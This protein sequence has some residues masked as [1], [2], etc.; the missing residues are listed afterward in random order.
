MFMLLA[1]CYN[2]LMDE[3]NIPRP[4]T[5]E[6]PEEERLF[7]FKGYDIRS[8]KKEEIPAETGARP[9]NLA[10]AVGSIIPPKPPVPDAF[11]GFSD[12]TGYAHSSTG[13]IRA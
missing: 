2:S 4:Q 11:A 12:G 3:N 8:G 9:Q 1:H 5:P 7:A 6:K 13:K 10:G